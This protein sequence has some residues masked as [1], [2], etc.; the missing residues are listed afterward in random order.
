MKFGAMNNPVKPIGPQI[1]L[2]AHMGFDFLDLTVE[3]PSAGPHRHDWPL[4]KRML[5]D[6][7]LGVVGHTGPYLPLA[8]PS[9]RVR[10]AAWNELKASLD[11]A[12][13]MGAQLCTMH[14]LSWPEFMSFDEG[15]GI[16]VEGLSTLTDYGK[17]KGVRIAIEN[18]PRNEHQLKPMRTILHRVPGLGLLYDIGHGNV[19]TQKP[20]T[21]DYL[22]D[23]RDRLVHVHFSDNDG[24]KDSHLPPGA[25]SKGGL[26]LQQELLKLRKFNYDGTV[27]LEVFGQRMWL[28]AS[29]DYARQ[30]AA[31]LP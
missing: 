15:V 5:H 14:F 28:A 6:S 11:I 18:S 30:V 7:G 27:T 2:F 22:F 19:Q 29:L 17:G 23:L 8:N 4:A 9:L 13:F 21:E 3:E 24:A 12:A 20:M 25:P 26:S 1:E 10:Q 31:G 16:Y